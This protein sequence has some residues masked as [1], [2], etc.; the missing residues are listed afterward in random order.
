MLL[1]KLSQKARQIEN[2]RLDVEDAKTVLVRKELIVFKEGG[3]ITTY[4]YT[5]FDD[6]ATTVKTKLAKLHYDGHLDLFSVCNL[7]NRK[8]ILSGGEDETGE[9][10]FATVYALDTLNWKWQINPLPDLN[11]ARSEHSSTF[12]GDAIYVAC[13]N[14]HN[15]DYLSSVEKL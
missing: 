14:D 3:P 6:P 4:K 13:G 10:K 5:N 7:A 12:L 11:I 9:R 8:I 1:D 2:P 15:G